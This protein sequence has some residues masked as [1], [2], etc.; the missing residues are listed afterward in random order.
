MSE[1]K[2]SANVLVEVIPT[3]F[4]DDEAEKVIDARTGKPVAPT[5]QAFVAQI[6]NGK[7]ILANLTEK[8][9]ETL[10]AME[11]PAAMLA[12]CRKKMTEAHDLTVK[13]NPG[14]SFD[15]APKASAKAVSTVSLTGL[16]GK[17]TAA[18]K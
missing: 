1:S 5:Y 7:S 11:V 18:R 6:R 4:R 14:R 10:E 12:E 2:K 3:K 8:R 17:A 9:Y 15:V 13:A 16:G